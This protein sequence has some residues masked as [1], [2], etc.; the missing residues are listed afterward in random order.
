MPCAERMQADPATRRW[1][2]LREDTAYRDQVRDA[3]PSDRDLAVSPAPVPAL[4]AKFAMKVRP[5]A[6]PSPRPGLTGFTVSHLR[7]P[8]CARTLGARIATLPP[9]MAGAFEIMRDGPLG[10]AAF[11]NEFGRPVLLGYFRSFEHAES[12]SADAWL[13]QADHARRRARQHQGRARRTSNGCRMA[14]R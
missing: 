7:I 10:G 2:T 9:R 3:Q 8:G 11:N 5:A 6:A 12:I 4:V 1:R 13:R 14:M